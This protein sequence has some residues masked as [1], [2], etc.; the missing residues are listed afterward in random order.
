MRRET[1]LTISHVFRKIVWFFAAYHRAAHYSN[2][3][4]IFNCLSCVTFEFIA[5][6]GFCLNIKLFLNYCC[7]C[8][9]TS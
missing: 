5:G 8:G 6:D 1:S 9:V 7:I 3:L 2:Q 4:L